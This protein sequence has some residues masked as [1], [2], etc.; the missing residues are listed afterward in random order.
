MFRRFGKNGFTLIE[1]MIVVA[2]VATLALVAIP[3]FI[4]YLQTSK[5]NLCRSNLNMLNR[6]TEA[7]LIEHPEYGHT[8]TL[9]LDLLSPGDENADTSNFYVKKRPVCPAGGTYLYD[10][11]SQSWSCSLSGAND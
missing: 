3:N 7:F 10:R 6:A 5:V 4:S 8:Q 1:I 11:E 9:T 2:I